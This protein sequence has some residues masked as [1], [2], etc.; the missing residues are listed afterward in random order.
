MAEKRIVGAK[1]LASF[2]KVEELSLR[3]LNHCVG[4]PDAEILNRYEETIGI[5][6]KLSGTHFIVYLHYPERKINNP[7]GDP[8]RV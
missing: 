4:D 7:N 2:L 1:E 5:A 6:R 8:S 3:W